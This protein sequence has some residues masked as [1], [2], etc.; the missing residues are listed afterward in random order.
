MKKKI[1][2]SKVEQKFSCFDIK[3]IFLHHSLPLCPNHLVPKEHSLRMQ[4]LLHFWLS[5]DFY[6]I[7]IKETSLK[8]WPYFILMTYLVVW[9]DRIP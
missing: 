4:I 7:L 3:L 9:S 8:Y 1:D 6:V 2:T 5:L